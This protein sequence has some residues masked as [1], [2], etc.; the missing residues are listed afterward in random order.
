MLRV[1]LTGG[2]GSGKSTVASRLRELGAFL[3]DADVVA[4]EVVEPGQPALALIA[5]RFGAG[6]IT[7]SGRL[8]RAALAGLVFTDSDALADLN[9][10][11]HPRMAQRTRE[12]F[13]VAHSSGVRVLVH[14]L[15]LLVEMGRAG[16]YDLVVVVTAPL[17]TRLARLADRGLARDDALAR[18]AA[19]ADD[20]Q[21]LAVADIV[22]DNGGARGDTLASV[23]AAWQQLLAIARRREVGDVV[24]PA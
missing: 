14:D 9:A 17:E 19:Q 7:A 8:D 12:L 13:T 3:I 22:I 11:I 18:I 5:A 20:S 2:I 4:R 21:R 23:D 10:I 16:D 24:P 6:V 15:A 1:G